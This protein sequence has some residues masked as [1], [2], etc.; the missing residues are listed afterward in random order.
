MSGTNRP[1]MNKFKRGDRV[2]VDGK[3]QVYIIDQTIG[4]DEYTALHSEQ[5]G[6][7]IAIKGSRLSFEEVSEPD[8]DIDDEEEEEILPANGEDHLD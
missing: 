6:H 7:K 2:V 8:E 5:R 4:T 3:T 1:D